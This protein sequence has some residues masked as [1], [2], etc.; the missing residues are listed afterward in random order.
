MIEI[1][2]PDGPSV[3]G[4]RVVVDGFDIP[5]LTN[6]QVDYP[7]EGPA[8]VTLQMFSRDGLRVT[9]FKPDRQQCN[10]VKEGGASNA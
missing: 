7:I 10:V 4:T 1:F 9:S 8:V 3:H 6:V 2:V 5:G